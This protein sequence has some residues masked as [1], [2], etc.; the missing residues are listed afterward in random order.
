[1]RLSGGESAQSGILK[2]KPIDLKIPQP[3]SNIPTLVQ[4]AD[5]SEQLDASITAGAFIAGIVSAPMTGMQ[6][7]W[8]SLVAAIWETIRLVG[9]FTVIEAAKVKFK[10]DLRDVSASQIIEK[11]AAQSIAKLNLDVEKVFN[12]LIAK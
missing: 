4:V 12:N 2:G 3:N 9:D 10:S 6:S 11:Q 8:V 1:M 5:M 7:L